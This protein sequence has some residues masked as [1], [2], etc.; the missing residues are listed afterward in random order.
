MNSK[1]LVVIKHNIQSHKPK[2][3]FIFHLLHSLNFDLCVLNRT[4][5]RQ[6]V[7]IRIRGYKIFRK[8]YDEFDVT[9]DCDLFNDFSKLLFHLEMYDSFLNIRLHCKAVFSKSEINSATTRSS[10]IF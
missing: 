4:W 2:S 1:S 6:T 7:S 5:L 9:L 10:C 8:Y 3:A